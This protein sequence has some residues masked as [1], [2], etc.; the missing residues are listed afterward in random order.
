MQEELILGE[1]GLTGIGCFGV[2]AAEKALSLLGGI[3]KGEVR[4]VAGLP[5][6]HE[7]G[8]R[9]RAGVQLVVVVA[10]ETWGQAPPLACTQLAALGCL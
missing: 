10:P 6:L 5:G 9:C 7:W 4:L 8:L 1:G 2:S 3:H